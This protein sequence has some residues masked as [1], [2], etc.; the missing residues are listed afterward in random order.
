MS[1]S[2]DALAL[3]REALAAGRAQL[4][5]ER[6]RLE[7][8]IEVF[9]ATARAR[10]AALE[11]KAR[12]VRAASERLAAGHLAIVQTPLFGRRQVL[13]SSATAPVVNQK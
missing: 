4:D 6:A 3:E 7:R 1:P 12:E 5:R 9:R 2:E 10:E 13:V 8:R 11:R